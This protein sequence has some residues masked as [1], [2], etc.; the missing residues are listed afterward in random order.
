[1]MWRL[2]AWWRE[3]GKANV[4]EDVAELRTI[5]FSCRRP[6]ALS[7]AEEDPQVPPSWPPPVACALSLL[8]SVVSSEMRA[9]IKRNKESWAGWGE[10]RFSS[11]MYP[12]LLKVSSSKDVKI[13]ITARNIDDHVTL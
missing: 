8:V 7:Q 4:G 3:A 2:R 11:L 12:Y 6:P 1:M 10:D 5:Q 9:E 13:N